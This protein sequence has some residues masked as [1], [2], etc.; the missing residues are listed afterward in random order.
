VHAVAF[1]PD[2]KMLAWGEESATIRLYDLGAKKELRR[3]T[4]KKAPGQLRGVG[5]VVTGLAFAPDSKTL[6]SLGDYADGTVRRW[7]VAKGEELPGYSGRPGDGLALAL[8]PDGKALALGGR[9]GLI[10]VWDTGTGKEPHAALGDQA[11]VMA[12][13]WSPDGGL[14]ATAGKDGVLRLW[15]P[16]AKKEVR[17]ITEHRR[18]LLA[19]AFSPDGKVVAT[20]AA[21]EPF[22]LW[23]AA[24]GKEFKV[25]PQPLN[26]S[27]AC[28]AF[29]PD[30]KTL[31]AGDFGQAVWLWDVATA[32]EV[33]RLK[34]DP[35]PLTSVGFAPD[36]KK[37]FSA[38]YGQPA[39]LWDPGT[40][41]ELRAFDTGQAPAVAALTP[42]GQA[43]A[44]GHASGEVILWDALTGKE[45]R[46]W[47]TFAPVRAVALSPDGRLLAGGD[48]KGVVLWEVATGDEVARFVGHTAAI[49]GLAFSPDGRVL[50]SG[51]EDTTVLL[52]DA[53]CRDGQRV[54]AKLSAEELDRLWG[55]LGEGGAKAHRAAWALAS[56]PDSALPFLRARFG[57]AQPADEKRLARLIREL[58]D[59]SFDTREQASAELA[60][61]GRAAEAALRR[62]VE[63]KPSA[64][65]AVRAQ[66]LLD[67]LKVGDRDREALRGARAVAALEH[68]G[69]R[70]AR[71]V[72]E[73][74][75]KGG[76]PDLAAQAKAAL[77]RL[78]RRGEPRLPR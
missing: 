70:E 69:T 53:T 55:E 65:V 67:K 23:D 45:R 63:D 19:V 56:A 61:L 5:D 16:A 52:W 47:Q 4:G 75:A 51:A 71:Q 8:A 77:G 18:E 15:D 64:E 66:A 9:N 27:T 28:L 36:G 6:Y 49:R 74:V 76:N 17:R 68:A 73:E 29:A 34:S 11:G 60:R 26:T 43:L 1:S 14:L 33:R 62:A 10:R 12:L 39:R 50:A 57:P 2:G 41:K 59:D 46:R 21:Y 32:K 42:D 31:A 35:G 24:T 25:I 7:D 54:L 30:G 13:A 78:A 44:V 40:G 3:L 20:G 58:D 48:A 38:G 37:L 22:R 72:L